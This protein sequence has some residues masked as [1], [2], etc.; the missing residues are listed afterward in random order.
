MAND[1]SRVGNESLGLLV[2]FRLAQLSDL[3]RVLRLRQSVALLPVENV[4]AA[5]HGNLA[6]RDFAGLG[7]LLGPLQELPERDQCGPL[8]D[9]RNRWRPASGGS[10]AV[11]T[12]FNLVG[13]SHD[14]VEFGVRI[15]NPKVV[16]DCFERL[17]TYAPELKGD[18]AES[19]QRG[20][21]VGYCIGCASD[22]VAYDPA[23]PLC[24]DCYK[25]S[26]RG[27]APEGLTKRV[28]HSCGESHDATLEKPLCYP[29]YKQLSA[30][31]P[32]SERR[33]QAASRAMNRQNLFGHRGS[34]VLHTTP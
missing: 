12:S 15:R 6:Y 2:T 21:K 14:S 4:V 3:R 27:S 26:K 16:A 9:L 34:E 8:I 23:K 1:S 11:I 28:C 18:N 20:A 24:R 5:Q 32:L 19:L 10:G 7:V 29:C 33:L 30:G 13:A 31:L 17:A 25:A 22:S